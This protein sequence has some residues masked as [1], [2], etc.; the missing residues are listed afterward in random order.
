VQLFDHFDVW[1]AQPVEE[2]HLRPVPG[3]RIII[4]DVA[5]DTTL[6]GDGHPEPDYEDIGRARIFHIMVDRGGTDEEV[7]DEGA[8]PTRSPG[9]IPRPAIPSVTL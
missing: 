9:T 1:G 3:T 4:H 5:Y 2:P 6:Q 7:I 8:V